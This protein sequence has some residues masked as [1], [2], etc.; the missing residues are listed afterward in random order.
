MQLRKQYRENCEG[1]G[2]KRDRSQVENLYEIHLWKDQRIKVSGSGLNNKVE[3]IQEAAGRKLESFWYTT[4]KNWDKI[5]LKS[6]FGI[7]HKGQVRKMG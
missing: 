2:I 3:T 7:H 6:T 5:D 1:S 4:G